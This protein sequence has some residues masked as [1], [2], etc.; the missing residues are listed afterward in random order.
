MITL[1]VFLIFIS[2]VFKNDLNTEGS[3]RMICWENLNITKEF[4]LF[5]ENLILM[6]LGDFICNVSLKVVGF[7]WLN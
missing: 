2:S 7:I 3:L 5:C 4:V 6:D 1:R